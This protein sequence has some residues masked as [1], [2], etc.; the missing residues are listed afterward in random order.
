MSKITKEEA[1]KIIALFKE[2]KISSK[3]LNSYYYNAKEGFYTPGYETGPGGSIQVPK[4][5]ISEEE[6]INSL[7][8]IPKTSTTGA[9][10]LTVLNFVSESKP[11]PQV[12][13]LSKYY[14]MAEENI[15]QL[16]INPDTCK[17]PKPGQW[18][19]KK[20]SA[21]V[22]IDIFKKPTDKFGYFQCLAPVSK[23]PE[24]KTLD[25]TLEVLDINHTLFGVGMTKFKDWIYVKTIRE[26][27]GLDKTEMMASIQRIGIY[28][29]KYDDYFKKKYF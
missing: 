4:K 16:G 3:T 14:K 10:Y 28:A 22:I 26:V 11:K 7:Q 9:R 23:I 29:D 17:G 8:T 12:N 5:I 6:V 25:F 20:G 2:G 21:S 1:I 15:K 18:S 19:I 27:V 24:T 13:E